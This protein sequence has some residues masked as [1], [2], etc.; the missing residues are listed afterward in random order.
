MT[1]LNLQLKDLDPSAVDFAKTGFLGKFFN[2]LRSYFAKY[3]KADAVISDIIISLD[4]GKT[5][6]KNDN[7]TLE[8]EQQA[9]RELTKKLQ[10]EIQLGM[11]MDQEIETQLEAAKLRDEDEEKVRFITEEVLFPLRQR[12]MDLQQMLVVNQQGIIV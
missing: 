9:L 6:L 4:K 5:V 10:K 1:E 7:T 3:Q 8:F 2:P 11:L 12:V